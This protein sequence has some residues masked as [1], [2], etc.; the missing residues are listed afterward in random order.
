MANEQFLMAALIALAAIAAAI[1]AG[2]LAYFLVLYGNSGSLNWKWI[3]ICLLSIFASVFSAV[4]FV[5]NKL[6]K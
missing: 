6:A 3:P 4:C 1:F 2:A 5:F